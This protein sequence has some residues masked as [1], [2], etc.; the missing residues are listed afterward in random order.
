MCIAPFKL[1]Y[2]DINEWERAVNACHDATQLNKMVN[3]LNVGQ[4]G[5]TIHRF[6]ENKK[7]ALARWMINRRG[8]ELRLTKMSD[9]TFRDPV[10]P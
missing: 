5:G 8:T 7:V 6:K 9:G 3:D 4:N 1:K 2:S 10:T